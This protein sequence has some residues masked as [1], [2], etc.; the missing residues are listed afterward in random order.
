MDYL[1]GKPTRVLVADDH[2][3][4]RM[5]VGGVLEDGGFH[6]CAEASDAE[7][8]I[9]LALRERPDICVLDIDMPGGGVRAAA[10]ISKALPGVA[11]VMLT[12]S[13]K[14]EDVFAALRAGASGYLLKDGDPRTLPETLRAVLAG[15][16][17]I[18][19]PLV[20]RIV[21]EFRS[22]SEKRLRVAGK[23]D[24]EL[25]TREWEVLELLQDEKTT[26]EIAY[27]L[28]ISDVTVRR[29]VSQLMK[30]LRARDRRDILR[31]VREHSP[32]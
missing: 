25:T 21:E 9:E 31:L 19:R 12:V 16:A 4:M 32:D 29:H 14:D 20:T 2:P 7:S 13:A 30:K 6:V 15:E 27:A 17:V 22:R 11:I 24:V 18:D 23:R 8:A 26:A 10:E 5:G 1:N 3:A 28:S